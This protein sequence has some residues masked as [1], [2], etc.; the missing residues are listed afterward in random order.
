MTNNDILQRGKDVIISEKEAL[1]CLA[2]ELSDSFTQTVDLIL[3]RKG[4]VLITGV[5][6]SGHI[7]AKIA[8]TMSSLG[9]TAFFL[10]PDDALH[11]DLGRLSCND[12]LIAIS[13][14]GESDELA[15]LLPNAR[16]IGA[17]I[18]GITSN[19]NSKLA[20]MSDV[21]CLVPKVKE[22]CILGMAPTNSTTITLALGDAICV[23][24]SEAT[25]LTKQQYAV[26]HPSGSLGKGLTTTVS[27]VMRVGEAN[28]TVLS[29]MT[30]KDAI[31]EIGKKEL[32]AVSV[33]DTENNLL[34]I[35][36]DGDLRRG[37]QENIDIYN[38]I[39][40][41]IM[42]KSPITVEKDIKAIEVLRFMKDTGKKASVIPVLDGT[43][44]CGIVSITDIIRL[45]IVC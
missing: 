38:T 45:G 40:D 4:N 44:L 5:G 21:V 25:K 34:G 31:V 2:E 16:L 22:A 17:S 28:P 6:K 20:N 19:A 14:S 42:T 10:H 36:T 1:E 26:F 33:V 39:V 18:I 13:N 24:L 30:L 43:T 11:G 41:D 27:D 23:V 37:M 3:N 8:A 29:G 35:I 9:T 32:G 7:A 15:K 12:V